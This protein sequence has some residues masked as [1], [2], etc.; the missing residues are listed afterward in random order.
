MDRKE[1]CQK[2]KQYWNHLCDSQG[3]QEIEGFFLEVEEDGASIDSPDFLTMLED[4]FYRA[5]HFKGTSLAVKYDRKRDV[6]CDT[7]V[8]LIFRSNEELFQE[9][10]L[11]PKGKYKALFL[12]RDG[13]INTDRGY[14]YQKE[15]L[16]W[17]EGIF[18][19]VSWAIEN[20]YR[21][22]VLTNQSGVG[23]G[24]YTEEDIRDLHQHMNRE[25][26]SRGLPISAWYYCPFH[27]QG[28]VEKFRRKSLLRKPKPGLA[29]WAREEWDLDL[30]ISLMVGDKKSDRLEGLAI[31]T[32]FLKG[33]YDLLG[34]K[35]I[36]NNHRELI[37]FL[38]NRKKCL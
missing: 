34:E 38:K 16:E 10:P 29:L 12:D 22:I 4:W 23:K 3:Q 21:I 19:L 37:V 1:W 30:S 8:K 28:A 14:V 13:V 35:N 20:Q 26:Q 9:L 27:E 6:Y 11:Y 17:Q 18:E 36:F 33:Q 7:G 25:F 2:V 15:N 24:Y 5:L 31:E 32:F